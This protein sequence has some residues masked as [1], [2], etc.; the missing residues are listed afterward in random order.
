MVGL[1]VD[2]ACAVRTVERLTNIRVDHHVVVDFHGFK[3]MVDALTPEE[4]LEIPRRAEPGRE[5]RIGH[6]LDQGYPACTTT[7]GWLGY[8][9]E[10]PARLAREAS[11]RASP[12][13]S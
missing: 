12:G 4:A 2:D 7:P 6:L 11:P 1:S 9:D 8:S 13:S 10:K 3:E 5:Q